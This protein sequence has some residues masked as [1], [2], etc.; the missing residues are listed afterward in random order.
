MNFL[1]CWLTS[2]QN[3]I[4]CKF[5]YLSVYSSVALYHATDFSHEE[6]SVDG[7]F[8][9]NVSNPANGGAEF[10]SLTNL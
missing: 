6:R 8:I 9:S 10:D 5:Q 3:S 2:L 4:S 1:G 7:N